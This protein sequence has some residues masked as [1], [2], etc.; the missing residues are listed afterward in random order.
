MPPRRSFAIRLW[1]LAL[2][3]TGF[4]GLAA[5][6]PAPFS[7]LDLYIDSAGVRGSLV[8]HDYDAAHELELTNPETLLDTAI[9]TTHAERLTHILD[10]RLRIEV[11]TNAAALRWGALEVL[12]DR[13]SLRF[14]FD[15]DKG[16]RGRLDV[17]ALLFPYDANHQSFINIYEDGRLTHQAILNA[18][19]HRLTYYTG[20]AQGRWTVVKTFLASG[21]HHIL[22]GPDHILFLLGLLLLGGSLARL[23][24]IVTAFT[25]GHTIT[26]SLAALGV[27][28]IAPGL[29]EPTI[30]LSI[31]VVGVDNLLVCHARRS[32]AKPG[33]ERDLRPWLAAVFGLTHGFG[34]AGVLLE[35][36]LPRGA[37]GW[38][39]AAFNAGVEVGQ[40]VI[41]A[42]LAGLM[43]LM[44]R[45]SARLTER[46]VVGG[47]VAVIAAGVY[48]FVQR[49]F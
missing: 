42:V 28:E 30:A 31:V 46:F 20:D 32:P 49:T 9:A 4:A 7:Y 19:G 25:V 38:S 37:M 15:L 33:G 2:A 23:A 39:L 47:S 22:A 10:S 21:V 14:P 27:V 6:H 1:L 8:V 5:A 45:H 40:L 48:W 29:V 34:F 43:N 3:L 41:V 36:G 26:L 13:Q 35:F 11:D 18:T 17:D 24:A 12:T 44:R 16:A